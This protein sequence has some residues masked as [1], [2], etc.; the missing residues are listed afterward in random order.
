MTLREDTTDYRH[1]FIHDIPLMDVRAPVEFTKGAFPNTV[2]IPLLDDAQ[3]HAVGTRYKEQG[4]DAAIAL[5]WQ[6]ATPEIQVS[7]VAAWQQHIANH[8]SG[9]LYCFRGGLR[10]RTSQQLL[11]KAGIDYPLIKGGYKAMRRFLLNEL[12]HN[13]ASLRFLCIG[14]RTC[15]GKTRAISGLA[16]ALDLE[17]RANHRGSAFGRQ[18]QGQPS[19]ID[20]ENQLS[21]DL[22]KLQHHGASIVY[23]EDESKLIGRLSMPKCLLESIRHS[24]MAVIETPLEERIELSIEDYVRQA[25]P[26]YK[27]VFGEENGLLQ[28]R[29]DVFSNLQRIQK[30]LG[31]THYHALYALF[32]TAFASYPASQNVEL[33]SPA[34]HLMLTEYYDPMYDYQ[35][36]LR[37][38]SVCFR[39]NLSEFIAWTQH[40]QHPV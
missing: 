36:R 4:Q 16:T 33:F 31:Q 37:Q 35:Y 6:L 22:I 27:A 7:R 13:S 28:Y 1:L 23:A 11:K 14:G 21:I 17:K 26:Q 32:E 8:P 24:P 18:L 19:Q 3:R 29:Q 20:F 34:I 9:Y 10:S 15:S 2:N 25:I 38:P 12:E 30:R 40:A 5:G 39:G